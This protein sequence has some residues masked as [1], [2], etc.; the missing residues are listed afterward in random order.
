[1]RKTDKKIENSL[2]EALTEVCDIALEQHEGFEWLTHFA[3]YGSF[4]SSLR[5]VCIF[6]S[7]AHLANAD[8]DALCGL[9]KEKLVDIDIK[10]KDIT[11]HVTFDTQENC[12]VENN[13]KWSDRFEKRM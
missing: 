9:I 4:P 8:T 5:I 6:D 2:R 12:N 3:N 1:M 13:G 10:L 7:N 11:R